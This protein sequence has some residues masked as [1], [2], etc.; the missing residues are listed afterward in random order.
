MSFIVFFNHKLP[1]GVINQYKAPQ[2]AIT[3]I[4]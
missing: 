3:V 2:L 1:A 4:Q